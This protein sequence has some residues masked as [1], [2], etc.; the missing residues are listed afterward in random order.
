MKFSTSKNVVKILKR[1]LQQWYRGPVLGPR[2]DAGGIFIKRKEAK[3]SNEAKAL[4][5]AIFPD[6]AQ[7]LNQHPELEDKPW[8]LPKVW[9]GRWIKLIKLSKG[10]N[11]NLAIEGMKISHRR[12]E[13]LKKYKIL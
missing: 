8:L 12:T 1:S 10:K 2:A 6:K 11:K 4:F 13:L 3:H 9:V 7:M 5:N